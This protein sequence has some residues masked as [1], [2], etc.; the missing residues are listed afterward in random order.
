MVGD[1]AVKLKD[2]LYSDPCPSAGWQK[3]ED[4]ARLY[5]WQ[6]AN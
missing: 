6:L 1:I 2:R 3:V 5:I 4:P